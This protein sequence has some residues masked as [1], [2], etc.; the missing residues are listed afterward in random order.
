M[1]KIA[2]IVGRFCL[3]GILA[4]AGLT[5]FCALYYHLPARMEDSDGVTDFRWAGHAFYSRGTEGF[6]AGRTNNEGYI[7]ALDYETGDSV[8]ILIIG[9]SHM[10]ALQVP[11]QETTT[12]IL[13]R[14]L[15]ELTVYN[16]GLSNHDF[17][18]CVRHLPAALEKYHPRRFAIIETVNL[19][20]SDYEFE[21][22]LRGIEK[23]AEVHHRLYEIV[24]KNHY[25]RLLYSQLE[26]YRKSKAGALADNA[27]NISDSLDSEPKNNAAAVNTFL[28]HLHELAEKAGTNLIIAYHPKVSINADGSLQVWSDVS[29]MRQFD[30]LCRQNGIGF[31]DMSNRIQE[32]YCINHVLPYGFINSAIGSGH[33]NADG[34][35]MF[36][37]ELIRTMS[38][39][40][41]D[42]LSEQSEE[43][44]EL[45]R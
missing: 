5:L 31:L 12:A 36:A 14:Q 35:R 9:S 13:T 16:V 24:Q 44:P 43:V 34:H 7:N 26:S 21:N 32:E 30:E 37:D 19:I 33:F 18:T 45:V 17:L 41:R 23:E 38:E 10:E 11:M 28:S 2:K 42:D 15:P 8:D 40:E 4:F 6:A 25:L 3:S 20:F 22:V 27:D 29:T 1:G 39:M